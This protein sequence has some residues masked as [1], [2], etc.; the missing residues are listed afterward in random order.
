MFGL[1]TS[2]QLGIGIAI[3]LHDQFSSHAARI[4]QQLVA[5]RKNA[6]SAL[7]GAISN[8]RNQAAGI[9][10]GAG[11]ISMGMYN[12]AQQGAKFQHTINQVAI[13][14]GER[15]KRS[16][17]DLQKF[18]NQMSETFI[19][20]PQEIAG[21]MVE[22]VRAGVT[23]GMEEI[24]RYQA[25]VATATGE[26]L[27]GEEGVGGKLLGIMSA[28]GLRANEMITVAGN[29]MSQF[30]RI[31][32][33]VTAAAN[34]TRASVYSIGESMEY[35]A[36][37][38]HL[39]GLTLEQS[40]AIMGKLSQ[41]GIMGASAGT[42]INNMLLQ[43][44][45]NA[46]PLAGPKKK[47]VWAMLGINPMDIQKMMDQGRPMEALEYV[48][49]QSR[50]LPQGQRLNLLAEAF[51]MRG[52]R[53]ILEGFMGG[54]KSLQSIRQDIEK[55]IAGDIVMKQAKA[56]TNDVFSEMQLLRNAASRFRNTFVE[57]VG[58]TLRVI[59]TGLTKALG[60]VSA[61][62]NTPIG[63]VFAGIV[64]VA[65]PLVGVVFAFRAAL[66]TATIALRGFGTTSA[67]GG[68]G[69]LFNGAL[70][71]MGMSRMGPLAGQIAR[72][73]A[74][75]FTVAAGQTISHAGKIYKG[76]QLLPNAL[77]A[78]MG[79]A[80]TAGRT[81]TL[82][83]KAGSFF[84]AALP[85]L[86]RAAGFAGRFLPVVGGVFLAVDILKM[87]YGLQKS[88]ADEK[89]KLDPLSLEYYKTLDQMYYSKHGTDSFYDKYRT[90]MKDRKDKNGMIQNQ[91]HLNVDGVN[92]A[93]QTVDLLMNQAEIQKFNNSFHFQMPETH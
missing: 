53:G 41:A 86:G 52:M 77:L 79:L 20:T 34:A 11:L 4:N 24:T 83:S 31:S 2:T 49:N 38:A 18:G 35:A 5:M 74:G 36:G 70:G 66:L 32:N 19:Q 15:L 63:K 50:K 60:V 61:I 81:A 48:D 85:W 1:G 84:G 91:I 45:K 23:E 57:A 71:M 67:V 76:G 7:T 59:I 75:R 64:A 56:M 29:R 13:L 92:M 87:I 27:G 82:A 8:Y 39:A 47:K 78:G 3:R 73:S 40:L 17:A 6:N 28:Y 69:S 30:A 12:M 9:A 25:A 72:N 44:I 58:P 51:N 42:A 90:S 54:E 14:G 46:G 26:M 89:R 16:R 88:D 55:G 21:Q 68:F 22:N 43:M 93:S 65:I 37:T 62:F 80:G 33:A 10:A